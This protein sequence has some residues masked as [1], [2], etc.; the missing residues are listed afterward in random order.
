V[1]REGAG[2]GVVRGGPGGGRLRVSH[3]QRGLSFGADLGVTAEE[4]RSRWG[5]G[6]Y[7]VEFTSGPVRG[8]STAR[9]LDEAAMLWISCPLFPASASR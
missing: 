3:R 4:L 5:A 9:R 7:A 1:R 8:H 6:E 2:D